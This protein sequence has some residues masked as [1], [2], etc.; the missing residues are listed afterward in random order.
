MLVFHTIIKTPYILHFGFLGFII[1]Q[2]FLVTSL[3]A[4][5]TGN[6]S[7]LTDKLNSTHKELIELKSNSVTPEA[8]VDINPF[9]QKHKITSREKDVIEQIVAGA[10]NNEIAEKMFISFHTVRRHLNNIYRKCGV[11]ERVDL[12]ELM[13]EISSKS[14]MADNTAVDKPK[15]GDS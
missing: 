1:I 15:I 14:E 11:S 9:C 3:Y 8:T 2:T 13:K 4:N 7:L 12:L 10:T 6:V 5:T